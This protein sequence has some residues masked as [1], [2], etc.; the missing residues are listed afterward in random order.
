MDEEC[1]PKSMDDI[2]A[3]TY[4]YEM[5][6]NPAHHIC[7]DET[8]TCR[9]KMLSMAS[10]QWQPHSCNMQHFDAVAL[11]AKLAGKRIAFVGDSI[12]LQQFFSIR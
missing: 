9:R 5:Y 2:A 12:H 6:C 4:P 3:M 1:R 11:D 8:D 10:W 7:N